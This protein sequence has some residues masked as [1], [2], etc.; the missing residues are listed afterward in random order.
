MRIGSIILSIIFHGVAVFFAI[1]G[2][3]FS[4]QHELNIPPP[5]VVDFIEISEVTETDK[6][7]LNPA[8]PKP[9]PSKP[10]KVEPKKKEKPAPAAKNTSSDAVVPVPKERPKLKE[11]EESKKKVETETVD[12]N[13]PP[14][15]K[16]KTKKEKEKKKVKKKPSRDFSSVLKNLADSKDESASKFVEES[17]ASANQGQNAP[18]GAKMTMSEED[19]LR[20]QLETCWNVPYGAKDAE[21]L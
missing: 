12:P 6:V 8:S 19:A 20:S 18:F 4:A 21:F 3:P 14:D 15:K 16:I 11:K 7:S 5:I 17:S 9:V 10:K 1:A 2:M 13:V